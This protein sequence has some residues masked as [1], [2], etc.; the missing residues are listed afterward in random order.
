MSRAGDPGRA[1]RRAAPTVGVLALQ[2]GFE[3]HLACLARLGVEGREVRAPEALAGLSHLILPGGES[4]TLARLFERFGLR[5]PLLRRH[6]EGT[7]ALFGTCAG[8]ILLGREAG[9]PPPR[10]GLLDVAVE[11]NAF[12]PQ[13]ASDAPLVELEAFGRAFRCVFIRAP[14]FLAP[15]PAVRVLARRDGAPILV[16]GPGVLAASFHPELTGDPFLHRYFLDALTPAARPAA[17]L[18]AEASA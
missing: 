12:G 6:A 5:E 2:G 9:E 17:A 18:E 8:A 15:G 10:L 14:R 4:T 7:L 11:R 13:A 3:P 16:Q 1:P